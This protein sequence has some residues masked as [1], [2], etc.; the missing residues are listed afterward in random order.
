MTKAYRLIAGCFFLLLLACQQGSS[1]LHPMV[2]GRNTEYAALGI[3]PISISDEVNLYL[4]QNEGYVWISYDFPSG[5]FGTLDLTIESPKL[6]A[7]QNLHVSAQL[8]E[9]PSNKPEQAPQTPTSDLWWNMD[10]WVANPLWANGIDTVTYDSPEFNLRNGEIRE[11]QLSKERFGRG[12]WKIKLKINAI[13]GLEGQFY[14][15]E[16]PQD[17]SYYL[18]TAE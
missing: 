4:F 1:T 5:S 17:G 3:M 12:E 15:F 16:Y 8:G 11:V 10:G 9:W 14:S 13:K 7:P 6:S 18:L 2:D